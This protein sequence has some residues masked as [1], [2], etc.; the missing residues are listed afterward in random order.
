MAT[1]LA[2]ASRTTR[3]HRLLLPMATLLTAVSI[4]GVSGATFNASTANPT[5]AYVTGSLSMTNSRAGAA[6]FSANNLKPGDTVTGTVT[7]TNSGSLPATLQVVETA[8]NGHVDKS[9]LTMTVTQGTTTV[10]SGQ[11]GGFGTKD[12]G[13]W[14]ADESRTYTFRVTLDPSADNGEQTKSSSAIYD[15]SSV[16]TAGEE[17]D[18][19]A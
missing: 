3:R 10:Y 14:A 11:F 16:Q 1:T 5:N 17:R 4:V 2:A 19:Q 7:I 6:V 12:L 15:W 8:T 9:K 18:G 13:T